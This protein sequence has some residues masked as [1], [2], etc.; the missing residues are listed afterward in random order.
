MTIAFRKIWRD[1][2][3]YKGRTLLVVL[4][5]AVG[6]MAL[7][8]SLASDELLSRQMAL[9][10]IGA[11]QPHARLNLSRPIND[12]VVAAIAALP[13]VAEAEGRQTAPARW[14]LGLS[15]EWQKGRLTAP[16]D[17]ANQQFDRLDFRAGQWPGSDEVMLEQQ[18]PGYYHIPGVGGVVYI[19]VNDNAYP[20]RVVGLLRD[21][22]E[23]MPGF[24]PFSEPGFYVSRDTMER[25]IGT[26]DF[27]QL[28]FT[29][30]VYSKAGVKD[31]LAVVEER[32][33]RLGAAAAVTTFSSDIQDP[34][35]T[36]NQTVLD[37]IGLI[38][39]AMSVFSLVLGVFLV[40]NTINAIVA[41]Q[42]TQIGIMKTV[43]GLSSQIITL[44]L[45]GAAVYGGLSLLI[46]VPLGALGG[47]ALSTFWL[48]V[49]NVPLAAFTVL[50]SALGAQVAVGLV[51]PLAAALW[52]VWQG[53][54]IPVRQAIAAYGLGT[55][56]YGAGWLDR[57]L[58]R[59]QGLPR[60]VILAL[61]NSFRR[62]GR[63]ALTE[64][65]LVSAGAIFMMV[66]STGDSFNQTIDA[67]WN[68]WGFDVVF[69]F[70]DFR[71]VSEIQDAVRPLPGVAD[72]EVWTWMESEAHLP[73]RAA[74][75]DQFGVQL[76][77]V[78]DGSRQFAP[79][80]QAGRLLVPGDGHALVLNQKLAADMGV[81]VGDPVVMEYGGDRAATWTVVGTVFDIG[82]S[83]QQTTAFARA[84][85]LAADLHRAGQGTV[86]Q[87]ATQSHARA[88]Q[89]AVKK[90]LQAYFDRRHISVAFATGREENRELAG[91]LWGVIGGLLQLM[92]VLM[93][94]VG[95]IGLSG[96]LSLNV[97][98]R[99]REI[100][101]MRA[102]G[103]SSGDV[104]F[105]FMGEGLLLGVLSWVA[106]VPLSLIGARYFVAALG[107]ALAFPFAYHY[108]VTGLWL[109][110]GIIL[111][112]S[113]VASWLPARRA[114]TVSVRESLAYE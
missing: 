2:W 96:T 64:I 44:Y 83:G 53:V 72:V 50:P 114:T 103:A 35:G 28:R 75:G 65:T 84:E 1:L 43:G 33:K 36:Q 29:I 112:L 78:P 25:L 27:N 39:L 73:G 52:P 110:L 99:R 89:D 41:Q 102:V 111:A 11:R 56:H 31:A 66:M 5:T 70:S 22:W 51:A 9:A 68:N 6:V 37:G 3:N 67:V 14:K 69:I 104:A 92:T 93:A 86:A 91:A 42:V 13:Q 4:S 82:I 17:F 77:G 76:R 60:M 107:E 105:I 47:Y 94:V 80:L 32:L 88:T 62:A 20:L 38:L 57:L 49:L 18:H 40:I 24:S 63:V 79:T 23:L 98:E 108:S 7:G 26:R 100:G 101:V 74:V 48:T 90:A 16:A 106:A 45:A 61:R 81:G 46:A 34:Q 8:M 85:V 59:V 10:R 12:D 87:I 21:P 113:V 30:P 97:L 58:S 71:R 15:G 109:W 19:E 55:G 54:S 95:S